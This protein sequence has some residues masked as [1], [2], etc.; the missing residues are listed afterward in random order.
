MGALLSLGLNIQ[1]PAEGTHR[2]V[3][4]LTAPHT[5]PI[6]PPVVVVAGSAGAGD[7]QFVTMFGPLVV[8]ALTDFRGTVISYGTTQGIGGV[9]GDVGQAT[10][11]AYTVG[12][13]PETLPPDVSADLDPLRYRELRRSKTHD[14]GP[15][16]LLGYWSDLLISDIRP[17][18][19]CV[20]GIGVGPIAG[21]EYAMALALGASVGLFGESGR[22]A[23]RFLSSEGWMGVHRP[24]E[25]SAENHGML[26][27]FISRALE[28]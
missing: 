2:S 28:R 6:A 19:V 13:L 21:L 22:A 20:I 10:G 7:E 24:T 1:F 5:K 17:S 23:Q 18:D 26:A 16:Q 25:L 27:A 12:Y 14:F 3:H 8:E 9:A 11:D 4:T 15:A